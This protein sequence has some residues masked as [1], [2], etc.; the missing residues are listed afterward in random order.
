MCVSFE[1][2]Q[3][4]IIIAVVYLYL[5]DQC[6]ASAFFKLY[7]QTLYVCSYVIIGTACLNMLPVGL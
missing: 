2:F 4:N 7:D 3:D 1:Y 5:K 6:D